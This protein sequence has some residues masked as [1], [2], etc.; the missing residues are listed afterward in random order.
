MWLILNKAPTPEV[1]QKKKFN[2]LGKC[3]LRKQATETIE[4]LV[5][6]YPFTRE[7]WKNVKDRAEKFMGRRKYRRSLQILVFQK[8]HQEDQIPSLQHSL[9][10][11][12]S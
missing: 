7:V 8:G 5:M 6:T 1:L 2:G 4:H 9:G 10:S 12:A 11:V 3:S